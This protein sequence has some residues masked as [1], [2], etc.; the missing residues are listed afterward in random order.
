MLKLKYSHTISDVIASDD[1]KGLHVI[2]VH[3]R[4]GNHEGLRTHKQL[5]HADTQYTQYTQAR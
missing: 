3:I 1:T 2:S 4:H 5:K